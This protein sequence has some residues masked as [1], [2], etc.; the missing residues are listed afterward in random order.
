ML[1]AVMKRAMRVTR[2]SYDVMRTALESR[3]EGYDAASSDEEG[4][5]VNNI[6]KYF[7]ACCEELR[8][9]VR[10]DEII[11]NPEELETL[12]DMVNPKALAELKRVRSEQRWLTYS[13]RLQDMSIVGASILSMGIAVERVIAEFDV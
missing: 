1:A 11:P 7:V 8:P 13:L 9:E 2:W 6:T 3:L 5:S 12:G 4:D 10:Y